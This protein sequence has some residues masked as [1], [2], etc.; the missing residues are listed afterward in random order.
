MEGRSLDVEAF[1]RA[2][3]RELENLRTACHSRTGGSGHV[4]LF[5]T[6]PW[7]LRRRTMSHSSRRMPWRLRANAASELRRM[8]LDSDKHGTRPQGKWRCRKHR[9]RAAWMLAAKN[10]PAQRK[11]SWLETHIWHAKRMKMVSPFGGGLKLAWCPV[12]RGERSAYRAMSHG[13]VIH[14]ASYLEVIELRARLPANARSAEHIPSEHHKSSPQ[15]EAWH[16]LTRVLAM[17]M[18][19]RD[20]ARIQASPSAEGKR[21]V[22]GAVLYRLNSALRQVVAPVD[23]LYHPMAQKMWIWVHPAASLELFMQ[24][25]EAIRAHREQVEKLELASSSVQA[26]PTR[27]QR[28]VA[29]NSSVRVSVQKLE[30]N[31]LRFSLVGADAHRTLHKVVRPCRASSNGA[32]AE[33]GRLW[34]Q[35][36]PLRSVATLPAGL[37]FQLSVVDPRE[38]F[39]PK[40]A[41]PNSTRSDPDAVNALLAQVHEKVCV[42]DSHQDTSLWNLADAQEMSKRGSYAFYHTLRAQ[43]QDDSQSKTSNSVQVLL[44]A[45]ESM[46]SRGFGSGWDIILPAQWAMPF[47]L[48]F[49]YAGARAVG[50]R[51]MRQLH[52]EGGKPYFPDDYPDSLSGRAE[53]FKSIEESRAKYARRPRGK[54]INYARLRTVAPFGP[55]FDILVQSE[56]E[57]TRTEEC[58]SACAPAASLSPSPEAPAA[59]DSIFSASRGWPYYMSR[60]RATDPKMPNSAQ[61]FVWQHITPLS[62]GVPRSGCIVY[63]AT[64]RDLESFIANGNMAPALEESKGRSMSR[65]ARAKCQ[66][67]LKKETKQLKAKPTSEDQ[68]KD[69]RGNLLTPKKDTSVRFLKGCMLIDDASATSAPTRQVIGFITSG[70]YSFVRG[71]GFGCGFVLSSSLEQQAALQATTL[72][73]VKRLDRRASSG[74]VLVLIRNVSSRYYRLAWCQRARAC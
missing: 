28:R 35:L 27:K 38:F 36:E 62:R 55:D 7:H 70:D 41:Q 49:I 24:L 26:G 13:T 15:Q 46:L 18:N 12:D 71:H 20:L 48:A 50:L 66:N 8:K 25:R 53:L 17:V 74:A 4:R 33:N 5:Q 30:S 23:I 51:E 16:A 63:A 14:D 68:E 72:Q 69:A 34:K 59:T 42:V 44:L 56:S 11:R 60:D 21:V 47:W 19:A 57:Q 1:A 9:R 45:R 39:P 65:R 10:S 58:K 31:F 32:L 64:A 61:C 54:R 3:L 2:R 43:A 22:R 29:S 40:R 37:A 67:E 6:L 73:A 52:R